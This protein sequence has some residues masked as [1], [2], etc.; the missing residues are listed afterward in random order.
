MEQA[1]A[2]SEIQIAALGTIHPA[3]PIRQKS[4]RTGASTNEPQLKS[5]AENSRKALT[6]ALDYLPFMDGKHQ[7]IQSWLRGQ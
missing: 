5:D 7:Y 4:K 6:N 2:V 1:S 3:F